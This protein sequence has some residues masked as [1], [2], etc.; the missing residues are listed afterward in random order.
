MVGYGFPLRGKGMVLV[1][2]IRNSLESLFSKRDW[3]GIS[4][5]KPKGV[6]RGEAPLRFLPTPKIGG[7]GVDAIIRSRI[8]RWWR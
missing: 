4:G 6:Q 5:G 7:L 2:C 1:V 8:I 3:S